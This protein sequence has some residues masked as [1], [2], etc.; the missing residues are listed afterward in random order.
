VVWS[1]AQNVGLFGNYN[2]CLERAGGKYI[3]PFAQDDL[4]HPQMLA[5]MLETF[6]LE[7]KVALVSTRRLVI[8]EAGALPRIDQ[9]DSSRIIQGDEAIQGCLLSRTNWI[10]EPSAVMFPASLIGSGFDT[11]F[12]HYGDLEYWFRIIRSGRYAFLN[13]PLCSFRRHDSATNKNLQV[14]LFS[15]DL[16]RLGRLYAQDLAEAGVGA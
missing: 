5:R 14:L 9:L 8:E 2:V 10:G 16:L 1:N 7:P 15:L 12:Y 3:K 4:L 11:S 6:A 13:E